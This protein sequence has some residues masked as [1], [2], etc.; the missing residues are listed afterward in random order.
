VIRRIHVH[1]SAESDL[2]GIWQYSFEQWGELQADKYLDE[3]NGGIRK[4]ADNP[5]IGLKRD[6]VRDGYHVLFVGSHAVYYTV[7]PDSPKKGFPR[8]GSRKSVIARPSLTGR[9]RHGR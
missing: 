7:T 2:V 3:L 4:L 5:E 9:P 6:F 1:Q 8:Q